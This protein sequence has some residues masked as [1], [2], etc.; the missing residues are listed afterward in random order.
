MSIIGASVPTSA[1]AVMGTH[2]PLAENMDAITSMVPLATAAVIEPISRVAR[3]R[4]AYCA[5][6]WTTRTPW[7]CDCSRNWPSE[8]CH[9]EMINP[10][11]ED[12]RNVRIRSLSRLSSR[13]TRFA[14]TSTRYGGSTPSLL[15]IVIAG[16]TSNGHPSGTSVSSTSFCATSVS[17]ITPASSIPR[18]CSKRFSVSA[19]IICPVPEPQNERTK[20]LGLPS[21]CNAADD[22]PD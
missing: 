21:M 7:R 15:T 18:C 8:I 12:V 13:S 1:L 9:M 6:M 5:A 17:V 11:R 10:A 4:C 14:F 3:L 16:R 2:L 22:F 20:R 19:C